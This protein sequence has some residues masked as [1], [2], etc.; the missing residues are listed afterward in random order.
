ME[1]KRIRKLI[2]LLL[3]V[4]ILTA[5]GAKDEE[6]VEENTAIIPNA[7]FIGS[8]CVTAVQSE[9]GVHFTQLDVMES[10]A[11]AYSYAG[12]ETAGTSMQTYAELL[13][14]EENGFSSVNGETYRA[15][16]LP[17]FT[18]AEGS[19]SL[20][21]PTDNEKIVVVRGD[22]LADQC[23]VTISIQDPP[24]PE[25]KKPA[26]KKYG[27]SH[28]GAVEYLQALEPA[29]LELEGD[30]MEAYNIY[31]TN[32]FTYVNGEACLRAEIYAEDG[33]ILTNVHCGTYYMSGDGERIY[34]LCD[35]GQVVEM[36]QGM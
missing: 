2:L 26:K 20:S 32:G 24:E 36:D 22:W 14:S 31:I 35:N 8:E 1:A 28:V 16:A 6:V 11:F 27:L 19:M 33:D 12:F 29:V 25:E 13:M 34:R 23:T 17:D 15:A 5:C 7:Y 4:C 21:R 10:G 18:T 9:Q 30:S 3:A